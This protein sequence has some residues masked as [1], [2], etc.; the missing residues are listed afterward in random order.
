MK[1]S[2]KED[3]GR[4]AT[5]KMI[6]A[7]GRQNHRPRKKLYSL[8]GGGG[9]SIKMVQLKNAQYCTK[10]LGEWVPLEPQPLEDEVMVMKRFYT[11]LKRKP[12]YKKRVTWIEE[13][14]KQMDISCAGNMLWLNTLAS[15]P[16]L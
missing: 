9:G 15:F 10:R 7:L 1:I 11:C 3:R 12:E 8:R 14:A 4:K 5:S 13:V 2:R 16:K 6:A